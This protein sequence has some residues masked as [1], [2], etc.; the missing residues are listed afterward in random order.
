MTSLVQTSV[1]IIAQ[2]LEH[3]EREAV[4]G[5]LEEAGVHGRTALRDVLG[6]VVRRKLEAWK[7]WRPWVT[8]LGLGV[9]GS[10]LLMAFSLSV[11]QSYQRLLGPRVEH[12]TGLTVGPGITLL[13]CNILL[14]IGWSWTGGFVMGS[15]SRRTVRVS[16]ISAF[17]PCLFCLSRFH[18]ES[19]SRFSLLLFLFPAIWGVRHG[20]RL[21]QIKFRP[22]LFMAIGVTLL[23]I[24]TWS[25]SGSWLPNWALSWPAWFLVITAWRDRPHKERSTWQTI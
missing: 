11:S 12:F 3:D 1:E 13:L 24:P 6:L 20:L 10:F 7:S 23:T 4:L 22:A 2:L 18:V 5:D 25:S 17:V 16:A 8:S 15:V 14:L 21:A 9:P 19:I